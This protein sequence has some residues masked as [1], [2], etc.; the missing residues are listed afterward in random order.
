M[1]KYLSYFSFYKTLLLQ[2]V[3]TLGL[4]DNEQHGILA[5]VKAQRQGSDQYSPNNNSFR[6]GQKWWNLPN[7]FKTVSADYFIGL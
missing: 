7:K 6:K 3:R 2:N 1:I 4:K 5:Q